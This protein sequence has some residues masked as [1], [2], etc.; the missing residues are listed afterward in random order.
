[1]RLSWSEYN[2]IND[3][4]TLNNYNNDKYTVNGQGRREEKKEYVISLMSK[5]SG[6]TGHL[7][8]R[9]NLK[10]NAP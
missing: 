8:P 5:G 4:Y 7:S 6:K 9:K 1:M 2:N 3:E 10:G